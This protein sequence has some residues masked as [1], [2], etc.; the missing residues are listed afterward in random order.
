MGG[1][2]DP[3]HLGHLIAAEEARGQL[4]LDKVLFIPTGRPWLK[5]GTGVSPPADRRELV[6]RAIAGNGAFELS[7]I[8]L[9]RPG[10]SYTVDTINQLLGKVAKG[11]QLYFLMGCDS[12]AQLPRWKDPAGIV[13]GCSLAVFPRQECAMPDIA[14]LEKQVH[15]LR[16]KVVTVRMPVIAIS[17]TDIRRRVSRGLSIRYLVPESV[18]GYI[19]ERGLYLR[20][21]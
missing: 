14:A 20:S 15:G 9:E 16:K 2:F 12:L 10:P 17:S 18:E 8:E 6:E 1:T 4:Q 19:R 21:S 13:A 3:I 7:T 11:T 5:A